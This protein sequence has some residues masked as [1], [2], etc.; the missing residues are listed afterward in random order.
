MPVI[1]MKTSIPLFLVA[2]TGLASAIPAETDMVKRDL[3]GG[4]NAIVNFLPVPDD[5]ECWRRADVTW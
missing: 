2:I 3:P 4:A 5:D 1:K